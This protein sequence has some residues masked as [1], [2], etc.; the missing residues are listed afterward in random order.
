MQAQ[1][2]EQPSRGPALRGREFAGHTQLTRIVV[3]PLAHG[4][5]HGDPRR[6][7]LSKHGHAVFVE[8]ALKRLASGEPDELVVTDT[9]PLREDLDRAGLDLQVLTVA[10]MLGE[11][12]KR[13]HF[14]ES[15]SCLF[16]YGTAADKVQAKG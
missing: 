9:I 14:N 12:I 15:V 1:E 13:I 16:E 11:A 8:G 4:Q 6:T 3:V 7:R 2:T 5:Q 10:P